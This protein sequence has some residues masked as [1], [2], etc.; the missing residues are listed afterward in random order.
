MECVGDVCKKS[1]VGHTE[2]DQPTKSDF[3]EIIYELNTILGPAL[4][5][6]TASSNELASTSEVLKG[7]YTALYF[8]GHW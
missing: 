6:K 8:S 3:Q 2:V 5:R 4:L 7:N 1:E